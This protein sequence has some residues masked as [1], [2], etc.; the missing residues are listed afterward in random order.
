MATPPAQDWRMRL[1]GPNGKSLSN[2]ATSNRSYRSLWD[3]SFSRSI[4]GS[5][6]P[7]YDHTVPTGTEPS[8]TCPQNRLRINK[9]HLSHRSYPFDAP[10]VQALLDAHTPLLPIEDETIAL[11]LH[12]FGLFFSEDTWPT[13]SWN[14]QAK[15]HRHDD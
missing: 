11:L 4:P 13:D 7:G 9:S 14:D 8:V 5:K 15:G 10:S 3:G 12:R 2:I 1:R 6:L